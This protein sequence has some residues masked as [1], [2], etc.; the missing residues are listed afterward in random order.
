[1]NA[2]ATQP[3]H[4]RVT[5]GTFTRQATPR[6]VGRRARSRRARRG[7]AA[8][9]PGRRAGAG[10]RRSRGR[11]A[12]ATAATSASAVSRPCS[13]SGTISRLGDQVGQRDPSRRD[14]AAH[15]FG[16]ERI[17]RVGDHHRDVGEC[18]LERGG[19]RLRDHGI[20]GRKHAGRVVAHDP[21]FVVRR[22]TRPIASPA[23]STSVQ[24]AVVQQPQRGVAHHRPERGRLRRGA[25]PG[26]TAST[27][28]SAG[29]PSAARGRRAVG[30]RVR[31]R[32]ADARRTW[33]PTPAR[34]KNARL[35]RQDH[36]QPVDGAGES[37]RPPGPPAP[38][39]RRDVPEHRN[40]GALGG[41][42]QAHVK[43]GIVDG[44]DEVVTVGAE[45]ADQLAFQSPVRRNL[46][47]DL[48]QSHGGE[49][50]DRS[51]HDGAGR[52]HARAADRIDR[53]V[54]EA[55]PQRRTRRVRHGGRRTARQP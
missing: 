1:M 10:P 31:C 23:T 16:R 42:R 46:A 32:A 41:A 27:R 9:R 20:G 48:D 22:D 17:D 25:N 29:S 53:G 11:A 8:P 7:G 6:P 54:R 18:R 5:P 14:Q 52:C 13:S 26:K 33:P 37:R 43:A 3:D 28:A 19:S 51:S 47:Q 44:D 2:G 30:R 4:R 12:A 45:I 21:Q 40:A 36:R 24:R 49:P 55:A 34:S 35:E 39:L 38:D 50:V 15:Q